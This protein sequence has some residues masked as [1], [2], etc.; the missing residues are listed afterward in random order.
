MM[1]VAIPSSDKITINKSIYDCEGFLIYQIDDHNLVDYEFRAN[2]KKSADEITI[3]L[4]D[5]SSIICNKIEP[6]VKDLLKAN[7]KQ[8]LRTSEENV[9][10]AVLN[11]L[12]RI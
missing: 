6:E 2:G 1:K 9:K 11:M 4:E 3:L 7:K 10:K 5:C 12:C 8:I